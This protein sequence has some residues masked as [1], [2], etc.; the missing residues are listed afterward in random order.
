MLEMMPVSPNATKVQ[1]LPAT[2]WALGLTSLFMDISSELIH[3]LLPLFLVLN[4]GASAAVL[5]LIEGVAEATAQISRV[6][7]G[8]LSDVL[9]KRKALAVAGYSLAAATKPLLPLASSVGLVLF[10][11]FADRVGK[12]IRAAPRDA[13]IADVT[14]PASRGAAFG[15]RQSLDTIGAVVGPL[16]AIGLMVL[17]SDDIRTVLW[18]AVPPA[19]IAVA[20]LVFGVSEPATPQKHDQVPLKLQEIALLGRLYWLVVGAGAVFTMARFSEAFLVLRAQSGGLAVGLAPAVI[21]VMSIVFAASAYPAGRIQDKTGARP[22]LLAGLAALIA[23]DLLLGFGQSLAAIFAG[24]AL[25]G[26]HLGLTQGVLATLV[27]TSAPKRLRGTAFGLFGLV[28][29]LF[30]LLASLLAGVLW[31]KIGEGATFAAGAGFAA[32]ALLAFLFL[33]EPTADRG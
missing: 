27:A 31:V 18:F 8:W 3:G 11:R 22:L 21:A 25:W 33:K 12:G 5:G 1:G 19:L 2:V 15:L 4:L 30:S 20:I 16:A 10:A 17:F 24:I 7:S 9:G 29:G 28:T 23:A 14:P 32:I 6:F 13:L 26:L